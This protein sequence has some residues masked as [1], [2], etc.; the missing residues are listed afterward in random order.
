M[1]QVACTAVVFTTLLVGA[2][3]GAAP[4]LAAGPS[5]LPGGAGPLP[6]PG[7]LYQPLKTAPQLTNVGIW[8]APPILISGASA[9]RDGEYLYQ[10]FLYDDHGADG[11]ARDPNDPR[12]AGDVFSSPNGTY[13]YP[14][15]PGYA[16]NAADLVELRVK[17]LGD[18]TAFRVTLNTL[19]DPRL[20]AFTIAIGSPASPVTAFPHGA[21]SS[22]PADMF[23]TVHDTYA[24]LVRGGT[25]VAL[26]AATV[27][28]TRRQIEVRI[29]HGVWNPG[30]STVRLTAGVGLW[31][32]TTPD[33]SGGKYL[34]PG[35]TASATRP[36]GL[37]TLSAG[38]ASAFFNVAFRHLE[39]AGQDNLDPNLENDNHTWWRDSLQG[40]A[41]KSGDLSSFHDDVDFAKLLAHVDDDMTGTPQGVPQTGAMDRIL[42]SSFETE[43]GTDY[44]TKCD[45]TQCLGELRGRLQ[46]YDIY[47]PSK[48][49]PASGYGMTL[50]L[51]SLSANYNQFNDSR[52]QAQFGDRG[53]GSIVITPEARG[54]D[55][56]Y[57]EYAAADVFE[58]WQDVASRFTLD[59]AFTAIA[60]YSMGGYGTFRLGTLFPDLFYKAQ[61]TVPPPGDGIWVPPGGVSGNTYCMLPA[62]R[63]VP[64]LQ[65]E[66]YAD[67]LV[68][69]P[70][71]EMQAMGGINDGL[72]WD[73]WLFAPAEH[74]TL[75]INDQFQPAADWLGQGTVDRDPAHV[76]YVLNPSMSFRSLGLN[77]DHAYWL[78]GLALRDTSASASG[79]CSATNDSTAPAIGTIDVRSEGFGTGDAAPS[80]IQPGTGVLTGGTIPA[81]HYTRQ[82]QTWGDTPATP[83]ADRLDIT[84]ANIATVSINVT[85]ARVDC[86][87]ALDVST[88]GPLTVVLDG[89]PGCHRT[90]VFGPPVA[91]PDAPV[92]PLLPLV[93]AA[94]LGL[95]ALGRRRRRRV[96]ERE[97]Q[98][99]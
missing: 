51:H 7:I 60:G 93:A 16:G 14:T 80:G 34:I 82:F 65:W 75:A 87:A 66:A 21:N 11:V 85:R 55:G 76:T 49:P 4:A 84:A 35:T 15:G 95:I 78:S 37:G 32:N 24:E 69:L 47:I 8:H 74:L 18:A 17:P 67:E 68:P 23:V 28:V 46:P 31:D 36:G 56:W 61:P 72:R 13:T 26:P 77:A 30:A 89:A 40:N 79:S 33:G 44:S 50:L 63:N 81:L 3:W 43:Q 88:D 99:G 42:S 54:P 12:T 70:G 94:P 10:D 83:V 5:S 71:T 73:F 64:V 27:D 2:G 86:S 92:A 29:P 91:T 39:P 20:A 38:S 25:T 1:R 22:A 62:L 45:S 53:T 97:I 19:I 48:T 52:N 98:V 59:P 57:V 58:V 9:Y 96:L 6:G 41:L 90:A